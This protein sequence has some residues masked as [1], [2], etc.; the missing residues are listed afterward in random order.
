VN[1]G[2]VAETA[3]VRRVHSDHLAYIDILRVLLITFVIAHHSIKPYIVHSNYELP[4]TG[5]LVTR[6]W[7]FLWVNT[8]FLMALFLFVSGYFASGSC[9]QRG[10]G[11]FARERLRRLGIPLLL[12]VLLVVPEECWFRYLAFGLPAE[13]YWTYFVHDFLGIGHRPAYW[14][15]DRRWPEM[16]LEHLW[17]LEHLLIYVLVLAV[18]RTF[19]PPSTPAKVAPP[20]NGAIAAFALAVS[21]AMVLIRH[22]F[23]VD[24]WIAFL[25]FIQMEPAY[26]PQYLAFF[27]IGIHAGPRRWMESMP[28]R[29]GFAWL[30]LGAAM[31]ILA[32]LAIGAELIPRFDPSGWPATVYQG[33]MS[34]ALCVGLP[35]AARELATGSNTL[36]RKLNNN[37][38]A[39]YVF[40][41]LIALL[42]TSLLVGVDMAPWLRM[43]AT[44][45]LVI[46]LTFL[47]T[48]YLILALP[49]SRRF[50]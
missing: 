12:G 10:P 47:L 38:L 17:F 5:P 25:G 6:A 8:S 35:V 50:F 39:A 44:A 24:H 11:N 45:A 46:P 42:T 34:T 22:W 23:P 20:E 28:R 4:L 41:P 27:V 29:R 15:V 48:N 31:V 14:P 32:Y 43:T 19:V 37:A 21:A 3:Q 7:G 1:T 30:T 16:Q 18:W 36:W 2:A 33:V 13:G 40:H 26:L 49:G 9:A